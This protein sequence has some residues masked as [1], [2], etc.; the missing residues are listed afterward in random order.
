MLQR[1]KCCDV[2]SVEQ[3]ILG[4]MQKTKSKRK[5]KANLPLDQ[6]HQELIRQNIAA[7][8]GRKAIK[9]KLQCPACGVMLTRKENVL[10][11]MDKC[12]KDLLPAEMLP[13]VGTT[14]AAVRAST[15]W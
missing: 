15:A 9:A 5:H 4:V 2:V 1:S 13:Q 12:C 7:S 6:A 3:A 14:Q 11:H 10:S 8:M